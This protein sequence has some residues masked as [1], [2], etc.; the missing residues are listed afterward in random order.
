MEST[1]TSDELDNLNPVFPVSPGLEQL[2][3]NSSKEFTRTWNLQ[4]LL[5]KPEL[6]SLNKSNEMKNKSIENLSEHIRISSPEE[7]ED[8][9]EFRPKFQRIRFLGDYDLRQDQFEVC[10][11]LRYAIELREKWV[12]RDS[13]KWE[14]EKNDDGM[15]KMTS[16]ESENPMTNVRHKIRFENGVYHVEVIDENGKSKFFSPP[17]SV[18]DYYS[19]LRGV[20]KLI[21][22]GPAKSFCYFRLKLLEKRF[23]LHLLLNE[24]SEKRQCKMNPHRD[25]YNVRK[26]DNHVHHSACMNLKHFIRFIKHKIRTEPDTVVM[27]TPEKELTL[28][29]IFEELNLTPHELSI[30]ALDMHAHMDTFQRFDRFNNKYNPLGAA[31]LRTVFLK[32]DNHIKGRF[33]GELTQQVFDD[34]EEQKYQHTEYRLSIYG[35]KKSEWKI[36]SNWVYDHNLFSDKNRWLIQIPRIY[37]VYHKIGSIKNFNQIIENI[38]APLFEVSLNPES[39]PKLDLFLKYVVGFDSVDDESKREV[40]LRHDQLPT[41]EQWT[42]KQNP[43]Y[44]YWTYY[45]H[46]NLFVLNKLRESKGLRTFSYRPHAGEAGDIQHLACTFMVANSINHGI[47]LIHSPVLQY[48]YYITQ[49]GISVSPLSNNIL[50][51]DYQKNPFPRFFKR[52][53]NVTLSTDD[54]LMI[55]Y[56]KQSLVE[57]YSIAAQVWKLSNTDMCEIARNSVLQSGF[58]HKTK[59]HWIGANYELRGT[60]G[61]T[62]ATT[63]VPDIR[64]AF[65]DEVLREEESLLQGEMHPFEHTS[66]LAGGEDAKVRRL[67]ISWDPLKKVPKQFYS[68]KIEARDIEKK[69]K[70][71]NWWI[72]GAILMLGILIGKH[73]CKNV[74][75]LK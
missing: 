2:D 55:H 8:V 50:F 12:C 27:K 59:Q 57:E 17:G 48:L 1:V 36:V 74:Y 69:K 68:P 58:E 19:D 71:Q 61:N 40:P 22:Y 4:P 29:Q 42:Q 49:I 63:N 73:M 32:T 41:P 9:Y 65:R 24:K 54:P 72:P 53:L 45:I 11:R 60:N 39:N 46:A 70:F 35:K 13:Q 66:H 64:V 44:S 30:D 23:G 37:N 5:T 14:E 31:E 10:R 15:Y 21:T 51:L 34:L 47:N 20:M 25:F 62:T 3:G 16:K 33:L 7:R 75:Y 52:G 28:A 56:T 38:F 18:D 43:P 6:V 67:E 26:V